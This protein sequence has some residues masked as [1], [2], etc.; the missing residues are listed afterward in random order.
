MLGLLA[1]NPAFGAE[2]AVTVPYDPA[3]DS[4]AI[5]EGLPLVDV[6]SGNGAR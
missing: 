5:T 3:F 6:A 4:A 2:R 1:F